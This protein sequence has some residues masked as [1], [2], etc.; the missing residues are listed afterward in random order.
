M[1]AIL[2][3]LLC[4]WGAT[5]QGACRQAL[6]LGL[7]VSGSVDAAEY[8]LQMDGL[9]AALL[10]PEVQTALFAMPE[11]PVSLAVYEWSGPEA[12]RVIAPWRVISDPVA[13]DAVATTLRHVQ[14]GDGASSTA[15]GAAKSFGAAMLSK[16][17]ACWKR[18][19]DVS[20]D[21]TS[22]TGPRPKVVRPDG[23]TING[24][25]IGGGDGGGLDALAAYYHAYV[26]Q[27]PDAFVE[28]A[29]EFAS[30]EAAMVRKLKRELQVM[31][32]STR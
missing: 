3:L 29:A 28:T 2:P 18:V 25:V 1:R 20:G 12:Q 15:L 31:V 32:V 21:G 13:L 16:Q 26:V 6:A 27:G 30:F 22:N 8:R 10:H 11:A 4:L 23:I 19:L 17:A 7:D 24:L 14:R 9:A 5:A